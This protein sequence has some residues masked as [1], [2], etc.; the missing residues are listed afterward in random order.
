MTPVTQFRGIDRYIGSRLKD[1]RRALK[2]SQRALAARLG[3]GYQRIQQYEHG[4]DRISA[5]MLFMLA[6]TL[7]V[8]IAYF[9]EGILAASESAA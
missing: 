7:N 5:A 2:L 6:K 9:Y 3:V 8:P 1:R 4:E